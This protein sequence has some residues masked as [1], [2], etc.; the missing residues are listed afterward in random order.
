MPILKALLNRGM[1][2]CTPVVKEK[3][4]KAGRLKGWDA[5]RLGSWEA[6]GPGSW[7]AGRFHVSGFWPSMPM[8]VRH[9]PLE[10]LV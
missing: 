8:K 7:G 9:L 5:G 3:I 6:I 4:I 1:V 10:K 2:L